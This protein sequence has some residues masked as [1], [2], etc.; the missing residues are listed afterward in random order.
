MRADVVV[1][2]GGPAGSMAAARLARERSVIIVEE[3]GEPGVP[4]QCAGLVTPRGV[5]RFAEKSVV[6]RVRGARIHSPMGFT[7]TIEA[8]DV[9][10]LVLDR[11]RFDRTAFELAVDE[12][13]Q[14][15]TG[16][17]VTGVADVQSSPA[18]TVRLGN[19]SGT[20]ESSVVIGADGP[21]S[22]CRESAGLRPPK[23]VL[24]GIQVDLEGEKAD[25]EFVDLFLGWKVAPGFFAWSIPA[26]DVTRVG[27]CTW[28]RE[29]VPATFLKKF[30]KAPEFAGMAE[31]S[32][33]SGS[34]PIGA[35]RSAVD[36]RIMLVGDAA[37]H[38]KPL[39]GG[40]IY[41][42]I[43]GAELCSEVVSRH[44]SDPGGSPLS[45]YDDLWW[46]S[47]GQELS[48]AFR[49]RKV[50]LAL[51]D[52]KMDQALRLFDEPE[53]RRLVEERGDID[54]PSALSAEVLKLAP[55]LAQFSPQLIKSLL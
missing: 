47:F 46:D 26:G 35:G 37:C 55:K 43:K 40:G 31:M 22:V 48:R 20:I 11:R 39:S 44:L 16:T 50:F 1:V 51:T 10:A 25:P 23:Q 5:P 38:A 17:R 9:R 32:R 42:G 52:K 18:A 54:R 21:R 15:L 29:H 24:R 2:G 7:L 30:L 45:D 41:T 12:G 6:A 19:A 8:H 3:H 36:G 33:A 13:A 14:A 4:L 49:I 28:G 34:I 53:V 27:L